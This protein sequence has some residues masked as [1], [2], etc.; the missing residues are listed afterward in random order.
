MITIR[1][2][3]DVISTADERIV[4]MQEFKGRLY[5]AT[6]SCLYRLIDDDGETKIEP[7]ELAWGE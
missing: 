6:E 1:V 2:A 7:V 5:I 4:G 3:K